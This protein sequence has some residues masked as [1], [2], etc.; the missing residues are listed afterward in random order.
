MAL[1]MKKELS[2]DDFR[3]L[4]S[5]ESRREVS[6]RELELIFEIFDVSGDGVLG[7]GEVARVQDQAFKQ[8]GAPR[9]GISK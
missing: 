6:G 8:A 9:L 2:K 3:E 4:M 1:S 7:L 5:K